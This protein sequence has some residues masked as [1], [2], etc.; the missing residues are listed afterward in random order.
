MP[1]EETSIAQPV[2]PSARNAAK[3]DCNDKASGVV[4]TVSRNW[5]KKPLPRVPTTAV[6]RPKCVSDCAIQCEHDV[7]PLVPVTPANH[8]LRD[9]CPKK[10]LAI[11]P[12]CERRSATPKFGNRQSV[13]H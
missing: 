9:G 12:A 1:C 6:L 7:L 13:F 4:L 11:S 5:P 2:A 8:M 10:R 3:V